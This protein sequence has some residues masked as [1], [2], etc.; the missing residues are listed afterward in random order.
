VALGIQADIKIFLVQVLAAVERSQ[1]ALRV[2]GTLFLIFGVMA[3]VI[4]SVGIYAVMAHATARRTQ[5][6]GVRMAL[7]ASSRNIMGLVLAR[8]MKQLMAGVVLGVAA[9]IP[10]TR[11]MSALPLQLSKSN[12]FILVFVTFVLVLV[13]I[14]A[15]WL[16]A[17]RAAAL[18]PVAAIR[19]E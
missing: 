10:A 14:F 17:R 11:A 1:W 5:E 13:G 18:N 7:G 2:F 16:P 12:P 19:Y 9:A 15:C 6:L 8:G 4:A 3:L